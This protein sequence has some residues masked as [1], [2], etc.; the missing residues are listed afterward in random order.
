MVIHLRLQKQKLQELGLH[1]N[2]IPSGIWLPQKSGIYQKNDKD[3]IEAFK[4]EGKGYNT[5]INKI[6]WDAVLEVW[7]T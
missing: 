7:N 1:M 4:D 5:R 3:V 6:L 2:L